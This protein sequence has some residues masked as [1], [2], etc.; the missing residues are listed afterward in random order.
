[1]SKTTTYGG[2]RKFLALS[3]FNISELEAHI[4]NCMVCSVGPTGADSVRL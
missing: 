4:F 3:A 2:R 1:M